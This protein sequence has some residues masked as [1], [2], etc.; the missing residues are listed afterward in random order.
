MVEVELT[1]VS[2][3]S[4]CSSLARP[5]YPTRVRRIV[6]IMRAA[7]GI[8]VTVKIRLGWNDASRNYLDVA[9]AAAE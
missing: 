2:L 9:R 6:E 4:Q 3:N 5:V 7:V 1:T 8:P